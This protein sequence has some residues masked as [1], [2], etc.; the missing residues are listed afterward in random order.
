[1]PRPNLME[2]N[3][4]EALSDSMDAVMAAEDKS[5]DAIVASLQAKF[6]AEETI[7]SK[8]V[9]MRDT[10]EE[11]VRRAQ[12]LLSAMHVER[13]LEAVANRTAHSFPA[14]GSALEAVEAVVPSGEYFRHMDLW[15]RTMQDA[16]CVCVVVRFIRS[17]DLAS[18]HAVRQLLGVPTLL[19]PLDEYLVGVIS[20]VSELARL[21]MNRATAGDFQTPA[22]CSTFAKSVFEGFKLLNFRNDFLR[23]RYDGMKYDV[24]RIEEIMYDLAVRG[25]LKNGGKEEEGDV[26][27]G[28]MEVKK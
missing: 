5:L 16:V 11:A 26:K 18:A 22:R 13:D 8:V 27:T 17:N 23:K 12:R 9:S 25:L 20:A 15:R 4:K 10:A 1:M 3:A 2:E 6:D 19:L 28:G 24:K 21:C 7:R 14:L